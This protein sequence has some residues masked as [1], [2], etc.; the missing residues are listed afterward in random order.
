MTN[1]LN[2][3]FSDTELLKKLSDV[4]R[5]VDPFEKKVYEYRN[6]ELAVNELH[7]FDFWNKNQVCENCISMRAYRD[8]S[9]YVKIE[10]TQ[11]KTY[12]VTAVPLGADN[13]KIVIE[14]IK[15]ITN[16]ILF[17]SVDDPDTNSSGIH[18]L[19]D[20]MNKLAF[21]DSLTGLYNRRYINE[22]LPV[23]L[24]N[25]ALSSKE[26]S[27]IMV[28]LDFFKAVNDTYGHL[29]GDHTLKSIAITLSGCVKRSSDW[30]A[31]F[32]GEEF[33][34]CMPG[35]SLEKAKSAA[36]CMR[37]SVEHTPIIYKGEEFNITASFGVYNLQLPGTENMDELINHADEKLYLAKNRGRNRVE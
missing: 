9:T 19:I 17:D 35:A 2:A 22:K 36:E 20:N 32:G 10:Y 1:E 3:Y 26:I 14:I 37:A 12:L 4:T 21:S 18:A 25:S 30:V 13:K 28:D 33:L 34:V 16:S 23:D 5:V 15:D 8:N 29:A 31:R 27:V 24:L 7:C 6:H 11:E